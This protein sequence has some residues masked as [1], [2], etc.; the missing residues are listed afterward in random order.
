[1]T[2][3]TLMTTDIFLLGHA[4]NREHPGDNPK[5]D[6]Q[7]KYQRESVLSAFYLPFSKLNLITITI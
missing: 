5:C 4:F 2:R 6:L 3:I 7:K 1:M